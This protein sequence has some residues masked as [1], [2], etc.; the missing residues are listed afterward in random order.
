MNV[1]FEF[2]DRE[3]LENVITAMH[4]KLD[5]VSYFGSAAEI[6]RQRK[7]LTNFLRRDCC[8]SEVVFHPVEEL[9]LQSI[10]AVLR[11]E[12]RLERSCRNSLFFDISGGR[13]MVLTAFG[14]LAKEFSVSL[15]Y[16]N[17][18]EDR[19]IEPDIGTGSPISAVLERR[20]V[21]LTLDRLIRLRGG[22]INDNL[23]KG[24][25]NLGD[26]EY[27][28]DVEN[29]FTV[30]TRHWEAWNVYSDL[31]RTVLAPPKGELTVDRERQALRTGLKKLKEK[32]RSETVFMNFLREL[33]G[34]GVILGLECTEERISFCYKNAG[35]KDCLWEGGAVLELHTCLQERK[36]GGD[37]RVGVHLDW[38]GKLHGSYGTDVMNEIDVLA[39]RGNIP[40]FI[41]CKTGNMSSHQALHALYELDT[42]AGRFG[43]KYAKKTL[44]TVQDLGKAYRE[45]AEEMG[46]SVVVVGK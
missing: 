30:A 15:H 12:I 7:S 33:A 20:D 29:I 37:C 39:L 28:G 21:P 22:V 43:G 4:F 40:T 23:H 38:D 44:M 25:K 8:V 16:Y 6:E 19:L 26:P 11:D 34:I 2:L 10:I 24:N 45:R 9:D 1:E 41:S 27:N 14:M 42:V 17:V 13:S 31:L 18:I 32:L 36:K 35:I 5:K 3:P 46:I